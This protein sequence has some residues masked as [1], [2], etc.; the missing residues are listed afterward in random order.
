MP[1]G[2][3][4]W[5][6][7]APLEGTLLDATSDRWFLLRSGAAI[8]E[9]DRAGVV[10]ASRFEHGRTE[11]IEAT[12]LAP[13]EGDRARY[14]EESTG[15][16]VKVTIEGVRTEGIDAEAFADPEGT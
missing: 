1:V 3:F 4:R 8:V 9:I 2:F 15:L 11:R 7:L 16:E 10:R 6:F 5:W 13:H 12:A 14:L